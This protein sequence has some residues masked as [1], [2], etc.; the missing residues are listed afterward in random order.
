M[1][2]SKGVKGMPR[3]RRTNELGNGVIMIY[4]RSV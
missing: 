4:S 1:E 2:L 3:R